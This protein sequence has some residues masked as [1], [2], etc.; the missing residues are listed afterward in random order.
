[1]LLKQNLGE[2]LLQEIILREE[3]YKDKKEGNATVSDDGS[4]ERNC[5]PDSNK[6]TD[7]IIQEQPE[8]RIR[9]HLLFPVA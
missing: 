9:N 5:I 1:M 8:Q 3:E 2:F 6:L 4:G 7:S